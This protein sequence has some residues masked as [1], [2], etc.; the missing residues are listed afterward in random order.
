MKKGTK[1]I[2]AVVAVIVIIVASIAGKYNSLV[3]KRE[4]VNQAQSNV[5]TT[6]QRRADLIPNLVNTVK[7]YAAHEEEIF[8]AVANARTALAG[9]S[10]VDEMNTANT[11][12]D[13]AVTRLLAIAENYPDL[14]ANENFINLQD[15]L[16]GTENRITVARNDY[17]AA[18][19]DYNTSIRKFPSN[20]IAN[21]F[22]FTQAEYFTANEEATT[23]PTVNFG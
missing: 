6:L 11:Q 1:I 7:G 15:E 2:I 13:S 5:Q 23:V 18:A 8:T 4:K 10:T 12:L 17:N 14:K 19:Q 16:A 20:I 21:M 3:S 9:A 22:G